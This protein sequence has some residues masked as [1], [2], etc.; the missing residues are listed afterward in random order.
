MPTRR[1]HTGHSITSPTREN[2]T[3]GASSR[4]SRAGRGPRG[5][6]LF[7]CPPPLASATILSD[8]NGTVDGLVRGPAPANYGTL[9]HG[10]ESHFTELAQ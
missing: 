6:Q 2:A 5:K 8:V 3:S 4:G 7:I 1:P 10:P 9:V